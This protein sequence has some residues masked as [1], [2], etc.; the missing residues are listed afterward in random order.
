MPTGALAGPVAVAVD[1]AT[2][3]LWFVAVYLLVVLLAPLTVRLHRRH[4][5]R[6][7]AGGAVLVAVLDV[8]RAEGPAGLA[9]WAGTANLLAVWLTVHQLGHLWGDGRLARRRDRALLA[10]TGW[11]AAL[12]LT[13]G[14]G[15]YP[16]DMQGLPGSTASNFAPPTL[17]LLAQGA[18]L[19]GTVLLLQEPAARLLARPTAWAVVAAGG[20]RLM[21]VFCWHLAAAFA[22]WGAVLL[23]GA[24]VPRAAT[25][26]WWA[27]VPVWLLLCLPVLL[28]LVRLTG[29]AER[30]RVVRGRRA[31]APATPAV[32]GRRRRGARGTGASPLGTVLVAAA[33]FVVSQVGV[34]GWTRSAT[35]PL[36][37][38]AVPVWPA[39]LVLLRR[40][41][42]P[43]CR[44]RG[45]CP[46][47]A[48]QALRP[49]CRW[50]VM[51]TSTVRWVRGGDDRLHVSTVDGRRVG[52]YDLR[53]GDTQLLDP[54]PA[55]AA[56]VRAAVDA[57]LV[58]T[59]PLRRRP[60]VHTLA[61]RLPA[62]RTARGA[63]AGPR[64]RHDRPDDARRRRRARRATTCA[65][66]CPGST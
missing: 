23:T 59:S 41:A 12:V 37:G 3:P 33:T 36:L 24:P 38:T 14:T 47:G 22:V 34:D 50:T 45:G 16:V 44:R 29:R 19:L 18:G 30:W 39:L 40:G 65:T 43:A 17:A 26:L 13:V 10:G 20:A 57:Y 55:A 31:P 28:L 4:G 6:A 49:A 63:T 53:T 58:T 35:E 62:P 56:D 51:V 11:A 7:V 42:R 46:E 1:R 9:P 15:W 64:G 2:T 25:P 32:A 54:D 8:V 61:T 60:P 5:L 48:A 52:W 21:T 27:L 66:G